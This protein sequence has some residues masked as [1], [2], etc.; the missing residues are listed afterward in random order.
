MLIP[1][2]DVE[3]SLED[4]SEF[5]ADVVLMVISSSGVAVPAY[6]EF[7]LTA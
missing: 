3:D 2:D 6:S 7:M 1:D 4:K 5:S